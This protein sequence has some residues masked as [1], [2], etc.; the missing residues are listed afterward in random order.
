MDEDDHRRA[1]LSYSE[2][3]LGLTGALQ[4]RYLTTLYFENWLFQHILLGSSLG[5]ALK[6]RIV[7][8]NLLNSKITYC[9]NCGSTH[10]SFAP[11]ELVEKFRREFGL[12]GDA[13]FM[14]YKVR[15]ITNLGI[16]AVKIPQPVKLTPD[17]FSDN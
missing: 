14:Q 4:Y 1:F 17:R 8:K 12:T 3:D 9:Y 10:F 16:H 5:E 11:G 6:E 2:W 13:I 7:Y 15:A